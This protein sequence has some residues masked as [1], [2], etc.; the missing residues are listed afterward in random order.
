MRTT[1]NLEIQRIKKVVGDSPSF[2]RLRASAQNSV[3][4]FYQSGLFS[5]PSR[6]CP[7][8]PLRFPPLHRGYTQRKVAKAQRRKGHYSKLRKGTKVWVGLHPLIRY[9]SAGLPNFGLPTRFSRFPVAGWKFVSGAPSRT[10]DYRDGRI[11]ISIRPSERS[12]FFPHFTHL[13]PSQAGGHL[14]II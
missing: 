3:L 6:P 5:P 10:T 4:F 7:L 9:L 14:R 12:V 13:Q 11:F 2:F 1:P 8:A